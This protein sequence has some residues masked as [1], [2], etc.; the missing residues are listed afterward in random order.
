MSFVSRFVPARISPDAR[1]PRWALTFA[2][3]F[4]LALVLRAVGLFA[5]PLVPEEAYYWLY[6]QHPALSYFDHPPM[7]AWVISAGTAVFGNTSEF[8]V[9]IVPCL[10]M[11]AASG[12][13]YQF[14]RIWFG[15]FEGIVSALLI[16][17][18]PIFF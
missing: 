12:L 18:L 10:L 4:A 1:P 9:R 8:G 14:G 7:V 17:A 16:Q 13:A 11:L 3:L 2:A 6:A 5:T 15:R